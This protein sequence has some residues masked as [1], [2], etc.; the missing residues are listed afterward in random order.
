MGFWPQII[1]ESLAVKLHL[2]TV[3]PAFAL[4]TWLIFASRKG[5][6]RHRLLGAVYLV[7]M[8]ATAV[9]TLGIRSINP[10]GFSVIHLFVP[11][12]IGSAAV[13]LIAVR[14]GKIE[15]HRRAMMGLYV[16]GLLIAGAFTFT[17]GRLMFRL[18]FG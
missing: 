2:L 14:R 12:T 4:G 10:P 13:A 5:S 17:P 18:I 16:G 11:L 9:T 6:P 1:A 7:L 8:C 15:T 3:I